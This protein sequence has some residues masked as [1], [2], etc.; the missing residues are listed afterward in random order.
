MLKPKMGI[1]VDCPPGTGARFLTACRCQTHYWQY[2]RRVS[3]KKIDLRNPNNK[4]IQKALGLWFDYHNTHNN[5][6][7]ENCNGPLDP[8]SPMSA[9]SCQAHIIPKEHFKSVQAVLD[10]HMTL[11]GLFQQCQCHSDYDSNWERAQGMPVFTLAKERFMKFKHLIHP[12]EYK[13]LPDPFK[14]IVY[15][16]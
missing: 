8:L 10:N 16:N 1:C 3:T 11:G 12:T 7:C 15:A 14:E 4:E 13:H 2:R 9:S 6:V 5:W